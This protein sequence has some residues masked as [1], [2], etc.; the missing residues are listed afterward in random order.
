[1]GR[2]VH[3]P[4]VVP[5]FGDTPGRIRNAGPPVP[6]HDNHAVFADLLGLTDSEIDE[7]HEQGVI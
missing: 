5:R 4:G 2:V 6:G 7:L 1:M 3:G